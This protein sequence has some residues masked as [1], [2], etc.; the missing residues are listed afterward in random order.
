L[1]IL[2]AALLV[3]KRDDFKS[4]DYLLIVALGIASFL[5]VLTGIVSTHFLLA[6]PFLLLCRRWMGGGAYPFVAL[7]VTSFAAMFGEVGM[8]SQ[9]FP[10]LALGR[11]A[12]SSDRFISVAVAA[13]ICAVVWLGLLTFRRFTPSRGSPKSPLRSTV[14]EPA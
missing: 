10:L 13:N 1:L 3:R 11:T 12:L 14:S 7:T 8:S 6:I 4:G 9:I 5:M 2:S